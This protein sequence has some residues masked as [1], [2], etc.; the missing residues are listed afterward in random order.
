MSCV[1]FL[2]LEVF[3]YEVSY[4]QSKVAELIICE[5]FI[6]E[7]LGEIPRRWNIFRAML[8]IG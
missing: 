3:R 4:L 7:L 1:G 2:M 8:R 5:L 6:V